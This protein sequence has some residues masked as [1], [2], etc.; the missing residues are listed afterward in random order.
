MHIKLLL[1]LAAILLVAFNSYGSIRLLKSDLFEPS[2]KALQLVLIW[3]I[4]L[5]GT[6]LVLLVMA[7]APVLRREHFEQF[8]HDDS[9]GIK[10]EPT[11]WLGHH[12]PTL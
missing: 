7:D 6:L 2:Q 9:T 1:I 8:E 3:A 10:G 5:F 12:D 11:P 4:P